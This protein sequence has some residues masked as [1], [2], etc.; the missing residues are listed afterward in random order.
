MQQVEALA[1]L[2]CKIDVRHL[3]EDLD[4]IFQIGGDGIVQGGVIK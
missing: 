3:G 1:I 4:D 2:D